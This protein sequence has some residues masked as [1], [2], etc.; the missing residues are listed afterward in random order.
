MLFFKV[1]KGPSS[2]K[3]TFLFVE[4]VKVYIV[5]FVLSRNPRL[6]LI[7]LP[8][9]QA[10]FDYDTG[11]IPVLHECLKILNTRCGRSP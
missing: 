6:S 9:L 8:N 4:S 2:L 1:E 10:H 3:S 7:V 11:G 5:I